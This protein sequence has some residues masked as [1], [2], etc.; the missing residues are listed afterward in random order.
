MLLTVPIG[1]SFAGCGTVTVPF[2][3]GCLRCRCE[4]FDRT[5]NQPSAFSALMTSREF[6]LPGVPSGP[7]GEYNL[8]VVCQESRRARS[9]SSITSLVVA[10]GTDSLHHG[11]DHP[12]SSGRRA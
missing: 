4:P 9:S 7:F 12:G 8:Y 5:S 6:T 10:G 2:F 1:K 3:V 11:S